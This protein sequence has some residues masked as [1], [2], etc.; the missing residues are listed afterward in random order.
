MR[1]K[2]APRRPMTPDRR[3]KSTQVSKF[4]NYIMQRGKKSVA[5]G[6][7]YRA[8]DVIAAKT[9]ED[10]YQLWMKAIRNLSPALEVKAKRVGGANY[11]VP[12]QVRPERQFTLACRWLIAAAKSRKG[13]P[14]AEK[15]AQEIQAAANNEGD[16]IKKRDDMQ[17][18][19]EA[20]RAFAH[21][22]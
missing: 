15:L 12:I 22:A 11:Q 7:V 4:I 2:Q 10:G 5:T 16:A 3:Y 18:A 1:G 19:A 13:K 21:F 20:N 17:R 14:M 6:V 8:F 9:G